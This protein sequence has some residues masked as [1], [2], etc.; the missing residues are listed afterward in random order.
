MTDTRPIT[1]RSD[2]VIPECPKCNGRM[3]PDALIFA[4]QLIGERGITCDCHY[5]DLCRDCGYVIRKIDCCSQCYD[6]ILHPE[7]YIK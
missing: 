6:A 7:K 4:P 1:K 2:I 5:G 3:D